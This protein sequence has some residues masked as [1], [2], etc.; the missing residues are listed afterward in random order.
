MDLAG[1]AKE[2]LNVGH[3]VVALGLAVAAWTAVRIRLLHGELGKLSL[4]EQFALA[5]SIASIVFICASCT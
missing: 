4:N 1:L 5:H 3:L 2:R